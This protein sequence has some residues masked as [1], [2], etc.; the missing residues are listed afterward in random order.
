MYFYRHLWGQYILDI[1]M[2]DQSQELFTMNASSQQLQPRTELRPGFWHLTEGLTE[3]ATQ[4]VDGICNINLRMQPVAIALHQ[5]P[6]T[7]ACSQGRG[8]GGIFFG[9]YMHMSFA[10]QQ[11]L[12]ST[13]VC[14]HMPLFHNFTPN[15][16]LFLLFQSN[17]L[18]ISSNFDK[19]CK[20]H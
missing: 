16:P 10:C 9:R 5:M 17:F 7:H 18:A 14:H 1:N 19:F 12:F 4:F 13:Q 15:D 2:I 20:S 6:S 3:M 8:E 11:T